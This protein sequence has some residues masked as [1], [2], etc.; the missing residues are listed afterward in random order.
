MATPEQEAEV[1]ALLA[2]GDALGT[3]A[4]KQTGVAYN[5]Q[6]GQP[7][8]PIAASSLTST[9]QP[10]NVPAYQPA[11]VQTLEQIQAEGATPST[12]VKD[13]QAAQNETISRIEALIGK[14]GT[15]A[16][17]QGELEVDAGIPDLQKNL[18]QITAQIN[19]VNSSAFKATMTAEDRL[20]PTFAI[21][22]E[23]AQIERQKSA[24]TFGL[25][26]A[27]SAMQNNIALANQNVQRALDAEFGA[28]ESQLRFQETVLNLNRDNLSK[29][30][31]K[32][33]QSIQLKIDERNRLLQ[34]QKADRNATLTLMTTL[35]SLGVSTDILSKVQGARTYDEAVHLAAPYMQ[36]P[37]AKYQLE[38]AKLDLELKKIQLKSSQYAYGQLGKPSATA[39][40]DLTAAQQAN[41]AAAVKAQ[42]K[43]ADIST[44]LNHKGLNS[45]VG[46]I[47]FARMGIAD[48]FGAKDDFIG[49][50]EQ[51]TSN[52]TLETLL[53]LK[54]AGGT[55]GALNEKE[56]DALRAAATKLGG[57]A[58]KDSNGKV[59]GYDIDQQSF[60]TELG[61]LQL[62]TERALQASKDQAVTQD[63]KAAITSLL[64]TG[65]NSSTPA[66]FNVDAYW[67]N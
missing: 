59:V 54:K 8:A 55:L 35:G 10:M 64:S 31:A 7:A 45:A 52:E 42:D 2:K 4:S 57:W 24:Q 15:Q 65:M 47:G 66:T 62:L 19:A 33:A 27:A 51:L 48:A 43:L 5:P 50:V 49:R 44:L 56:F 38:S 22:G 41:K 60:K 39:L 63:E 17:R 11:Q 18:N 36:S 53:N 34:E 21:Y 29:A 16:A 20:A 28:I 25:A 13:A 9:Q 46:P 40:A 1:K 37:E 30:E 14:Q 61:T 3:A 23:Q 12:E 32:Q 58:K 6:Y 67:K 26:A